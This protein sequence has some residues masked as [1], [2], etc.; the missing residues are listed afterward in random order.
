MLV[1]PLLLETKDFVVE[2]LDDSPENLQLIG[3]F[4]SS[5]NA[6]GLELYLKYQAINDEDNGQ[7]RTYL[8]KDALTH[9]LACYFSLR[10]CLIPYQLADRR[11]NLSAIELANFA[12]NDNYRRSQ[13]AVSKIGEYVFVEIIRPLA[14]HIST[15]V[16]AGWL[17]IFALPKEKLIDYY[18]TIL[19][20]SRLP[21]EKETFVHSHVKPDYDKDCVFMYQRI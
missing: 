6:M 15:C 18:K 20:F 14:K 8:V 16:G 4:T 10:T 21:I 17:C 11:I 19:G 7:S 3:A 1:P 12:V 13:R 5:N 2:H 9:E